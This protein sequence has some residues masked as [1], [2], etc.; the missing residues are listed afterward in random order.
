MSKSEQPPNPYA[1]V[2]VFR[3]SDTSKRVA[4]SLLWVTRIQEADT[5]TVFTF[6]D[7]STQ[8]VQASFDAVTDSFAASIPA[9]SRRRN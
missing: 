1:Q 2:A 7:G 3:D 4:V 6:L 9:K 5:D 8:S